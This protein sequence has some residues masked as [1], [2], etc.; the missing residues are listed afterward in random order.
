M[1]SLKINLY[2]SFHHL[3]WNYSF[4][5]PLLHFTSP[6][7]HLNFPLSFSS[8]PLNSSPSPS[9]LFSSSSPLFLSSPPLSFPPPPFFLPTSLLTLTAR[10]QNVHWWTSPQHRGGNTKG[11]FQQVGKHHRCCRHDRWCN[12]TLKRIWICDIQQLPSR[13]RLSGS[14]APRHRRER[15]KEVP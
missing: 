14:Q 2:L 11:L 5:F 15:C 9:P 8:S 7:T 12:Q 1:K 6:S 10:L 3:L 13:R 4:S